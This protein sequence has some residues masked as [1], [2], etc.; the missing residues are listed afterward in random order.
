MHPCSDNGFFLEVLGSPATCFN[1]SHYGALLVVDPEEEWYAEEVS[2]LAD[3]V[4]R[5]GLGE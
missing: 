4:G 3:D 1:A 5:L 2:K